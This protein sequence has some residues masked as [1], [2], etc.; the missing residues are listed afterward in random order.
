MTDGNTFMQ[1]RVMF[2]NE[3]TVKMQFFNPYQSH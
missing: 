3:R 2:N 1:L